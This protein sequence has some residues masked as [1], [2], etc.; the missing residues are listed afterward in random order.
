VKI[1]ATYRFIASILSLSILI[2]VSIPAGLHAMS[3][4]LCDEMEEMHHSA[5]S[6]SEHGED[7]PMSAEMLTLD[8]NEKKHHKLHDLG[9]ACAC[10]LE[11]APV[12]MEAPVFQKVKAQVLAVVQVLAENHN[13][14]TEFETSSFLTSDSYSP[15]PIYLANESFLI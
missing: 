13:T 5:Q 15:P 1:S 11:E 8:Q 14:K 9:F 6:M 3:V 12:K 2:G 10:S 7:C 4:D